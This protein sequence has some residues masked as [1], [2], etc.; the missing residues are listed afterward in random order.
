MTALETLL[1]CRPQTLHEAQGL[2]HVAWEHIK[3]D[4]PDGSPEFEAAMRGPGL[5]L[6]LR[7][8]QVTDVMNFLPPET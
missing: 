1:A 6:S 3:P 5:R 2:A 8:W 7:L 4:M